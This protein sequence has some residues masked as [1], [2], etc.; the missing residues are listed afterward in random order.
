MTADVVQLPARVTLGGSDAAAAADI[1]PYCSPVMLWLYKTGRAKR[2]QTEAMRWGNRLEPVIVEA[3]RDEGRNVTYP[4]VGEVSDPAR[5]WLVGHPDGTVDGDLLEVKT[6]NTW[7]HAANGDVPLAYN[8]QAQVY[9]H[10]TGLHRALLA[11]LVAGQRLELREVA[12]D[13]RALAILLDLAANFMGYVQ[14]DEPPPA[15]PND[16]EALGIL[17]PEHEPGRVIRADKA[18]QDAVYDLRARKAQADVIKVQVTELENEVKAAMGDAE[19]LI[20]LFDQPLASWKATTST[21]VDVKELRRQ[22]PELANLFTT[23]TTTRRFTVT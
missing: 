3:L 2:P 11:T 17:Y 19:T 10:L 15:G 16:R 1:D 21:R 9:M 6:A 4:L 8:A 18:L 14:R 7:A 13:D 5:P 22:R 20:G 12:R 23:E